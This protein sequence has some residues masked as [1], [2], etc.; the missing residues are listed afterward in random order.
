VPK[1]VNAFRSRKVEAAVGLAGCTLVIL[2]AAARQPWLDR[3]FLPSFVV[4][5]EGYV[6]IETAARCLVG[7]TGVTVALLA[8][9]RIAFVAV[10]KRRQL[11]RIAVAA[12]AAVIA[13]EAALRFVSVRPGEWLLPAEEPRRQT[14]A[15][16]GWTLVPDRTGELEIGGRTV[17]YAVNRDGYRTRSANDVVDFSSPTMIFSGESIV[18]GEG[19]RFDETIPAQAAAMVGARA[20]NLGVNGY[21]SDQAFLRLRQQLPRFQKPRAVVS[22]FMPVLF[23]RNLDDDRPRLGPGLTWMPAARHARLVSLARLF[24][25]YRTDEQVT[26]GIALTQDV[27][28]ATVDLARSRGA[29]PLLI[30]PHLG[31]EDQ[32]EADLRRR[33]LDEGGIA[34]LAVPLDETWKIAPSDRHPDARG[35][36]AIAAAIAAACSSAGGCR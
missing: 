29:R 21:S 20:V 32:T 19:L 11:A 25:P 31:V 33:V 13:A 16:L 30:V 2:A 27:L 6:W 26:R 36:R 17:E 9:R 24:V 22:I 28:R 34:Y 8:R 35:A 5:R 12:V 10:D 1:N 7:A 4:G 14:D 18:F 23:G 15:V 3:H